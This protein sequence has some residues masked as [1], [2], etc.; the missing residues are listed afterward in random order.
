M[1][2]GIISAL[3][4]ISNLSLTDDAAVIE[5]TAPFCASIAAGDSVS[6][7]GVCL[8]AINITDDTFSADVMGQTLKMTT[9]GK[10]QAGDKVNL[11]LA[12]LPDTRLG[13]HIVQGHVDAVGE[14][15][16]R[17]PHPDWEVVRI[18]LPKSISQY[19]VA[20]GSITVE[21]TSLTVSTLGDSWF[22]VSLIPTTLTHTNLG[23]K[24]IGDL[25]NLE[26]DI[27]ARHVERLLQK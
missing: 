12:M 18:S 27:L 5:I 3:G 6:V 25:V 15:L 14:I 24:Q 11:E 16:A 13:G 9:L 22:E 4:S 10:L 21:G 7:N 20:R 19:V 17:T 8:T 23:A 26:S 2:T 1:F